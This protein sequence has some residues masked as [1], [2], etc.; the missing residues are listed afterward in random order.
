MPDISNPISTAKP[1]DFK[2]FEHIANNSKIS[3]KAE[4]QLET[5]NGGRTIIGPA[6][7]NPWDGKK[8][9]LLGNEPL[10][11]TKLDQT[12]RNG[13]LATQAFK[14]ALVQRYGETIANAVDKHL[15]KS[16]RAQT[17][18]V[19]DL[20]KNLKVA[21]A[22]V[23]LLKD[24][25]L[26]AKHTAHAAA[27]RANQLSARSRRRA[28]DGSP[29]PPATSA[30]T[31][32]P[33]VRERSKSA[34]EIFDHLEPRKS[35]NDVVEVDVRGRR[36][37]SNSL[38][39]DPAT[40]LDLAGESASLPEDQEL[41]QT[42]QRPRTHRLSSEELDETFKQFETGSKNSTNKA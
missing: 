27:L 25:S 19:A 32:S 7:K 9:N 34:P 36:W 22:I 11:L 6:A 15:L 28:D 17:L 30:E 26:Q 18:T 33:K 10:D 20:R 21:A 5:T 37:R 3:G 13:V 40:A 29:L 42:L 31:Q 39:V 14:Q 16:G 24:P 12:Q 8:I 38:F 1:L 23:K 2:G 4:V 35:A 41:A